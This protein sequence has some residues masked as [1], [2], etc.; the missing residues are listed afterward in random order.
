MKM[1][2]GIVKFPTCS[3]L[4]SH[5]LQSRFCDENKIIIWKKKMQTEKKKTNPRCI[6]ITHSIEKK[7]P[8]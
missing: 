2:M 3:L 1:A 8:G 7:N 5:N 4:H 6:F